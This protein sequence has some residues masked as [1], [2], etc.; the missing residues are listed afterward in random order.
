MVLIRK[1]MFLWNTNEVHVNILFTPSPVMP[2]S[3]FHVILNLSVQ[4]N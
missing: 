4:H 2:V 1:P 3:D